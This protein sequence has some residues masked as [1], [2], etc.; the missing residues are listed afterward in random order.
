MHKYIHNNI[1]I[2]RKRGHTHGAGGDMAG[3]RLWRSSLEEVKATEGEKFTAG[4]GEF[5]DRGGGGS[6]DVGVS[7]AA[8]GVSLEKKEEAVW[9]VG[10]RAKE[11]E[12]D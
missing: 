3:G 5:D 12:E 9:W 11:V 6:E 4:H 7:Q 1:E 10:L 8:V 2:K